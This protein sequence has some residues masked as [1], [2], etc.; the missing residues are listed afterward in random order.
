MQEVMP[1]LL[2]HELRQHYRYDPIRLQ[3]ADI[4]DVF[5]E[6]LD[7]RPVRR[8]QHDQWHA[9][10]ELLPFAPHGLDVIGIETD[11]NRD[12]VFGED[13]GVFDRV[14]HRPLDSGNRNDH[15]MALEFR[16]RG[17]PL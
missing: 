12:Y 16:L 15:G 13:L 10:V 14:Q 2:G 1:P 7:H 17:G 6:R 8:I 3:H 11:I 9:H 4:V 5:H